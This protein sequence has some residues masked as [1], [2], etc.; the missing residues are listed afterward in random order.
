MTWINDNLQTLATL[1]SALAVYVFIRVGARKEAKEIKAEIDEVKKDLKSLGEKVQSID[2]RVARI[3]GQL[4]GPPH[5]YPRLHE[6]QE[7][8]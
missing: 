3:E 4:I 8:K 7:E 5:F 1:G 2:S 6:K